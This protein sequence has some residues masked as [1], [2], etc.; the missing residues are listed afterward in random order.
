MP[1][2][3]LMP[4]YFNNQLSFHIGM[5]E[6]RDGAYLKS[7]LPYQLILNSCSHKE[8]LELERN[9]LS[10][11]YKTRLESV[12]L[13]IYSNL[14]LQDFIYPSFL[15]TNCCQNLLPGISENLTFLSKSVKISAG[16]YFSAKTNRIDFFVIR[17]QFYTH[18]HYSNELFNQEVKSCSREMYESKMSIKEAREDYMEYYAASNTFLSFNDENLSLFILLNN[19]VA[20]AL[21]AV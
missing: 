2:L 12:A 1:Q 14:K 18:F 15:L 6:W 16:S 5:V 9:Y 4:F 8:M 10:S 3:G 17:Q 13:K 20:L 21:I 19:G 7:S 11:D